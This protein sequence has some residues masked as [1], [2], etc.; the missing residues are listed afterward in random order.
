MRGTVN[1]EGKGKE[2]GERE[3]KTVRGGSQEQGQAA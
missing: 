3:G 2:R 1:D